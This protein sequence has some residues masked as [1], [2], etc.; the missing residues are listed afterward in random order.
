M[1]P[2][3]LL[4]GLAKRLDHNNSLGAVTGMESAAGEARQETL[5]KHCGR[6][7][8]ENSRGPAG[9]PRVWGWN[10]SFPPT[11]CVGGPTILLF[12]PGPGLRES[13]D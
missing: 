5:P 13:V 9:K 7:L 11:P 3:I 12:P 6:Q 2:S 8:P 1:W 4:F 10:Y